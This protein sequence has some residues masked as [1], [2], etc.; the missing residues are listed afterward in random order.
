MGQLGAEIG[1]PFADQCPEF[2]GR[3]LHMKTAMAA[4]RA[5]ERPLAERTARR[6]DELGA[7]GYTLIARASGRGDRGPRRADDPT[8]TNCVFII[9]CE[10][11]E[12]TRRIVEGVRPLLSKSGGLCLVSDAMWLLH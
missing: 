12:L 8:D 9:A 10:D 2:E 5:Y 4:I 6:L 1:A 3:R 11:E 7:P